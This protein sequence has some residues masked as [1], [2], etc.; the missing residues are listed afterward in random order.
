MAYQCNVSGVT[1]RIWWIDLGL[2]SSALLA[3]LSGIYFLFLPVGGYQGGRNPWHGIQFL[4]TRQNWDLIH[5]WTG[6]AMI[7][8]AAL[9]L[10]LHWHWVVNMARRMWQELRG[11][12]SGLNLRGRYNL[13]INTLIGSS[14]VLAAISSVYFLYFP[15]SR[16][17][18]SPVILFSRSS[19]DL[20]HTWSGVVMILA[21]ALHFVIHW[22]W[23]T[24]VTMKI[25]ASLGTTRN[26]PSP[27]AAKIQ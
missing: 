17:S 6:V 14:F 25:G 21:A 26:H 2:F 1:R 3:S 12:S 9:H 24:K 7:I 22:K 4:F 13:I 15:G 19:W 8:I 5:T 20:L 10:I 18:L 11:H 27:S 16:S 23:V